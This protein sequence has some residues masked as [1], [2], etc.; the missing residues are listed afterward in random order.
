M[1]WF[2]DRRCYQGCGEKHT[3]EESYD[4]LTVRK[5][6]GASFERSK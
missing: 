4:K 2:D 1:A 5:I 6:V 3:H